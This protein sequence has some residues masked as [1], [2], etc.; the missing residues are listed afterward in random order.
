MA[1]TVT[2]DPVMATMLM[3]VAVAVAVA[4]VAVLQPWSVAAYSLNADAAACSTHQDQAGMQLIVAAC[5]THHYFAD[6]T[7]A[8]DVNFCFADSIAVVAACLK[9][10]SVGQA[11]AAAACQVRCSAGQGAGS[12]ACLFH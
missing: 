2:A 7:A 11:T 3:S 1:V 6:P 4:A 10:Y 9:N 8:T 5:L 12:V